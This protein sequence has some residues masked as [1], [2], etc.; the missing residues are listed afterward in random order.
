MFK[1]ILIANRGEIA[2]RVIRTCRDLG[3]LSVAIYSEADRD[4]MHAQIADE[5]ICVGPPRAAGSYLHMERI[6]AAACAVGADAIHPGY[7]FL[8][9]NADFA[10][11]AEAL[12]ITYIGPGSKALRLLG[13]KARAVRA[14]KLAGVPTIPG[15]DGPV[16]DIGQASQT[17]RAIGYPLYIKAVAGG[18][19]RGIRLVREEAEL[20]AAFDLARAE[21]QASFAA[22][23]VYMERAI[24]KPRHVEFQVLGDHHGQVVHLF[25]REC[26]I[27]RR[28]QKLIEESPSPLLTR[29]MR[30]EMGEAAVKLARAAGYHNA[31][32]VEFLV[33]EDKRFYFMEMNPRIQVEHPVTECVTG[34]DLVAEQIRIAAGQPLGFAQ[35]DLS[36]DGHAIE[37]RVNAEDPSKDFAPRPGSIMALNLPGGPGVRVD[38]AIYQGYVIPPYY[39]SLLAKLIVFGHDRAQAIARARRAMAEFLVEG[40]PTTADFHL[41]ILRDYAF[42]SGDYTV[43]FLENWRFSGE[44]SSL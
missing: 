15:S 16:H 39:D 29:E 3:I 42:A 9:E 8:S 37:C 28:H 33:G 7:G 43:E 18:G 36:L 19:G 30:Q 10:D 23:D 1:R 25:E 22:S 27:Q 38:A 13:D 31:G 12:G 44:D 34:M 11:R 6:L 32:T 21:A 20:E 35:E 14:A 17:A 24:V 26:S 41:Q 40:V 5:A 2:V 4:A